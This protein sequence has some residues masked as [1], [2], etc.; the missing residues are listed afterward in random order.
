MRALLAVLSLVSI[1]AFA[2][3]ATPPSGVEGT[4]KKNLVK[5]GLTAS[6]IGKS[7]VNG[8][9]Q[10]ITDR[11]LF[12]FS[13]NGQFLVHGK[14]YDLSKEEIENVTEQALSQVRIDGMKKFED[15][16]IVFPAKEEKFQVTV[17]TDTSCGY[18]R[19][20]HS[21]MDAYN[22]L[23]I[24]VRYLAFPRSGPQGPTFKEM[25]S[26]WCAVDQQAAMTNA[27]NGNRVTLEQAKMCSAPVAEQ[28][29]LG[30]KV[31][32]SGTPAI[33]LDDGTMIPG[34]QD[35]GQLASVLASK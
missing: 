35:P 29:Y 3:P 16:M 34:Y 18:C 26:I 17:F 7:P 25:T 4:I 10:V 2:A 13:E 30:S 31:G 22:D 11:G 1:T 28:Y 19:K 21:Q 20:L 6:E 14:V 24:T 8:L 9:Y 27:K 15:S 32:V 12:Y 23:G 33:V 5:L